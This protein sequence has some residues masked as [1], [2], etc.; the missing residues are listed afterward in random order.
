MIYAQGRP[1]HYAGGWAV[2]QAYD[3]GA[4]VHY[5]GRWYVSKT[6]GNQFRPGSRSW[7]ELGSMGAIPTQVK[8]KWHP[9]VLQYPCSDEPGNTE[10][11]SEPVDVCRDCWLDADLKN[12]FDAKAHLYVIQEPESAMGL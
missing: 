6:D 11:M 5:Q 7:A 10:H 3:G 4:V 8:H 9:Q 12:A 2:D 1:A